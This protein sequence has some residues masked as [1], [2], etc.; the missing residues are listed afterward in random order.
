[1]G[2]P[3]GGGQSAGVEWSAT[4]RLPGVGVVYV[5][6]QAMDAVHRIPTGLYMNMKGGLRYN[7]PPQA[8]QQERGGPSWSSQ[9]LRAA[10]VSF[11]PSCLFVRHALVS[12][13]KLRSSTWL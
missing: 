13:H 2:L 4:V 8:V 7:V 12:V 5:G 11:R 1:V 6:N 10:R 9:D 3:L